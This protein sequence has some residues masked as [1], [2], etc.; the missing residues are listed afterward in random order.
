[1]NR[2]ALLT[3]TDFAAKVITGKVSLPILECVHLKGDGKRLTV[4]G[5][6]LD[7]YARMEVESDL[8][9]DLCVR[10][11]MLKTTL[12]AEDG[13]EI[14]LTESGNTI[15]VAGKG[16]KSISV[17]PGEEFP[18][19]PE[20]TGQ[21]FA[22]PG[23]AIARVIHAVSTDETRYIL[24]GVYL[25]PEGSAWGTDGRRAASFK[26]NGPSKS[27]VIPKNAAALLS[28]VAGEMRIKDG[29]F[30]ATG[31]G[32]EIGGKLIEGNYPNVKQTIPL[33]SPGIV[34]SPDTTE[35]IQRAMVHD[36]KGYVSI[37]PDGVSS[38][39]EPEG[40]SETV[41]TG[42][43]RIKI[44]ANYLMEAIKSAGDGCRVSV[45]DDTSA[46]VITNEGFTAVIMPL[47]I[48]Q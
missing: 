6:N 16:R 15:V 19:I 21:R 42:L 17:L 4:T 25:D 29:K 24:N 22:I 9:I 35:A 32:W 44:N 27:A 18:P 3:A 12:S 33:R 37:A 1:M 45:V 7:L 46:V 31:D 28:G 39:V 20:V 43:C 26:I 13:E 36:E 5:Y 47:K 14:T 10:A 38:G 23:E 30:V 34:I 2:K 40:Y 41:L 11:R 8:V 48:S